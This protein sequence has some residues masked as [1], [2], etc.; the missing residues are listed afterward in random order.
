MWKKGFFI[1][2]VGIDGAGKST[3]AQQ[4]V[5]FLAQKNIYSK[6]VYNRYIPIITK[7]L[8]IIGK[9]L[10]FRNEDFFDNYCNYS[11]AKKEATKNHPSLSKIYQI[12]LI[13]D[14]IIQTTIKI[15]I[16]LFLGK[17]IICDRY[18]F[19]TIITDF[20]VDFNYSK[21][22]ITESLRKFKYFPKPDLIFFVDVSENIAFH[23]KKDIPSIEYL[24][25]RRYSYQFIAEHTGM[26]VIDGI[27][28]IDSTMEI[29]DNVTRRLYE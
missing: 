29:I 19:D 20:S 24:K 18:Y 22:R 2:F 15:L 26:H 17:N 25:E 27:L 1:C 5:N 28:P 13:I 9:F 6:Y 8:L 7:P 10:F 4:Y 12:I 16:P 23:R 21:D 3:I 11:T 14:Y